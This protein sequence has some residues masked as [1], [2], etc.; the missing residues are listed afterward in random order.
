MDMV[1]KEKPLTSAEQ[2]RLCELEGLI[3][4]NFLA[5][6][7][8]GSALLEIRESRLYRNGEGRT[9]EGYCRALWN[10]AHQYAN[11]LIRLSRSSK[12]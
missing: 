5:Y 9:W 12:I 7:T 6:V 11:R 4:D 10:M 8:V 1:L 3:R 2:K